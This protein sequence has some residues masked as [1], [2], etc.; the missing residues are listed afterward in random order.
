MSGYEGNR[1]R[2]RGYGYGQS[3]QRAQRA[4]RGGTCGRR[5]SA[6]RGGKRRSPAKGVALIALAAAAVFAAV[7]PSWLDSVARL[8]QNLAMCTGAFVD[9]DT[10]TP[11]GEWRKGEVPYLYQT[12]P[13][14]AGASYAGSTIGEAGCGPTS[15]AMVYACLTGK[16]DEGPAKM[17]RFSEEHGYVE[18]GAT[19]WTFMSEGAARLGLNVVELPSSESSVMTRLNDGEPVICIVGPGDF[20]TSGHFI[21]LCENKGDGKVEIRDP[22]SPANSHVDWS[23]DKILSQC[24][25]LWAY[26][27]E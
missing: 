18:A 24:R 11:K 16:K 15:L 27:L 9:A 22:N 1:A 23:L 5:A 10:S 14:W 13:Q 20:T 21:V 3:G 12:D 26:S 8:P 7:A 6:R 2:R 17:A 4:A 25:N 19:R